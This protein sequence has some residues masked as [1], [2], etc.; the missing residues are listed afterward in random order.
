[1]LGG[2]TTTLFG[3]GFDPGVEVYLGGIRATVLESDLNHILIETPSSAPGQ[4]AIEVIN[5]GTNGLS[6]IRFGA[7]VYRETLSVTGLSTSRGST[8]GGTDIEIYGAGF[9]IDGDVKVFFGSHEVETVQVISSSK[10]RIVTENGLLGFVNVTVQNVNRGES[11]TLVDGFEYVQ[12]APISINAGISKDWAVDTKTNTVFVVGNESYSKGL[13]R[14]IDLNIDETVLTS[15]QG[16]DRTVF[17]MEFPGSELQSIALQ[18]ERDLIYVVSNDELYVIGEPALENSGSDP[19]KLFEAVAIRSLDSS[20]GGGVAASGSAVYIAAGSSG[21]RVYN[22]HYPEQTFLIDTLETAYP[23]KD[24]LLI[25]GHT[26]MVKEENVLGVGFVEFFD[27]L[28]S[29]HAPILV[30]PWLLDYTHARVL[31]ESLYFASKSQGVLKYDL[32]GMMEEPRSAPV[33]EGKFSGV[34]NELNDVVV[35]HDGLGFVAQKTQG[36]G[37]L[38]LSSSH[39]G[40]W[41]ILASVESVSG[42]GELLRVE[43]G[44]GKVLGL[45]DNGTIQLVESQQLGISSVYPSPNSLQS[46]SIPQIRLN[47]TGEI[48]GGTMG[49]LNS[50]LRI[51]EIDGENETAFTDYVL[52]SQNNTI[53]VELTNSLQVDRKYRVELDKDEL[54]I[55]SNTILHNFAWEFFTAESTEARQPLVR[56]IYPGFA[57]NAG[58]TQ[59]TIVGDEFESGVSVTIGGLPVSVFELRG[60]NSETGYYSVIKVIVPGGVSGMAEVRVTNP[61]GMSQSWLGGVQYFN[62]I[63]LDAVSPRFVSAEGGTKVV[64][65]GDGFIP[66]NSVDSGTVLDVDGIPLTDVEIISPQKII[67]KLPSGKFGSVDLNATNIGIQS[68]GYNRVSMVDAFS[69][70][71]RLVG[72]T[73]VSNTAPKYLA[74]DNRYFGKLL[75][76]SAGLFNDGNHFEY[77]IEGV[78]LIDYIYASY[79]GLGFDVSNPS[80]PLA[81]AGKS[82]IFDS[83]E[84]DRYMINPRVGETQY[85]TSGRAADSRSLAVA[86]FLDIEGF[87][88]SLLLVA[89]GNLGLS[90]FDVESPDAMELL[91]SVEGSGLAADVTAVGNLAVVAVSET[92]EHAID[93]YDLS[94]PEDP[95]F[96]DSIDRSGNRVVVSND[97]LYM[98]RTGVQEPAYPTEGEVPIRDG[99]PFFPLYP[100]PRFAGTF[101]AFSRETFPEYRTFPLGSPGFFYQRWKC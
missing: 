39:S 13:L 45:F 63:S 64:V 89:N 83:E 70:G 68:E 88:R 101:G 59:L 21:V 18:P 66:G 16:L 57:T 7:Y 95:V 8:E 81:A 32:S 29:E 33:F 93:F 60:F 22:T 65:T 15:R 67:G 53:A 43:F 46:V 87:E 69:Y 74:R 47:F 54:V 25:N 11:A 78:P 92:D 27:V 44:Y 9:A 50:L 76:A 91:A 36:I 1:M 100:T 28:S 35:G 90:V 49:R 96:I 61:G 79:Y 31:D 5:A 86:N 19:S 56:E 20:E 72:K 84:F 37:Y 10:I 23:A 75:Y 80:R 73:S 85:A 24:V 3:G 94:D 41:S 14:W 82:T 17:E 97:T 12:D 38:D 77:E 62:P 42:I 30:E 4:V 2:D 34:G 52:N 51:I 6:D 48:D 99:G 58:G 55:S 98:T 40:D 26:L 71:L